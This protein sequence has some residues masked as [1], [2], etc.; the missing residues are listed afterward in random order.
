MQNSI[1][2]NL[3]PEQRF[4][5]ENVESAFAFAKA[6]MGYTLYPDILHAQDTDLC[7]IQI[8]NLHSISFGV[9]CQHKHDQPVLKRFLSLISQ[10]M[11]DGS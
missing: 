5:A 1:L 11:K 4:F 7:Y 6:Q 10:F 9:Y 2:V 8:T 3:L